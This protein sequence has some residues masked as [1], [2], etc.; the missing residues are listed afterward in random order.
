MFSGN[1]GVSGIVSLLEIESLCMPILRRRCLPQPP[2]VRLF[3]D[4]SL[5]PFPDIWFDRET[6]R[7]MAT[8][9]PRKTKTAG[10][11][12]STPFD[13]YL[14]VCGTLQEKSS[15]EVFRKFLSHPYYS[16]A[17]SNR[18]KESTTFLLLGSYCH[19]E[20]KYVLLRSRRPRIV[21]PP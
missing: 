1:L 14:I 11:R 16:C 15:T 17:H 2:L 8:F 6:V 4:R 5:V 3:H 21:V 13:G 12:C 20:Y 18:I 9:R 19:S 7:R 10:G